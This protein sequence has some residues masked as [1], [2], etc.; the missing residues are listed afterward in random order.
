VSELLAQRD[1]GLALIHAGDE[2]GLKFAARSLPPVPAGYVRQFFLYVDGWDKDAD[3]HVAMGSQLEPLPFHGM[4]AQHYGR[5][6][7]PAFPSDE[8]HRRYNTRWVDGGAL[9]QAQADRRLKE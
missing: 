1:E 6:E 9:R 7:R 8:L 2:L 3:F 5:E 4:N